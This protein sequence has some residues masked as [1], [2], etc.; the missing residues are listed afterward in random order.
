MGV[1][2]GEFKGRL[3]DIYRRLDRLEEWRGEHE[4]EHD[5]DSDRR[6]T[7]RRDG[8]RW[9]LTQILTALGVATAVGGFWLNALGR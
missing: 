4:D 7:E 1:G 3:D 2:R 5:E 6:T 8:R 9:T